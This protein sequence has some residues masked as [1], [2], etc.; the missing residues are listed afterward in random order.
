VH[1]RKL[2]LYASTQDTALDSAATVIGLPVLHHFQMPKGHEEHNAQHR[3]SL[4]ITVRVLLHEGKSE[5]TPAC[6]RVAGSSF[7][8][9][10]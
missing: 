9:D 4:E 10:E 6:K 8:I 1:A 3:H 5:V 7:D 2:K